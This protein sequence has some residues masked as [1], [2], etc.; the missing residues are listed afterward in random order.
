MEEE[1]STERPASKSQDLQDKYLFSNKIGFYTVKG[2]SMASPS[3]LQLPQANTLIWWLLSLK[4]L[5]SHFQGLYVFVCMSAHTWARVCEGEHVCGRRM[6]GVMFNDS[7]SLGQDPSI[8]LIVNSAKWLALLA[9][10]LLGTIFSFKGW[11]SMWLPQSPA[12][13]QPLR[14]W[15]LVL[16]FCGK[17]FSHWPIFPDPTFRFLGYIWWVSKHSSECR[18]RDCA[19]HSLEGSAPISNGA[20][21]S[22]NGLLENRAVRVLNCFLSRQSPH[23]QINGC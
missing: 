22:G 19:L 7:D 21:A 11:N 14:N 15:A 13:T 12:F 8:Q 17:Y 3:C 18:H 23:R 9:S 6:S 5:Q 4:G 1:C 20:F 10:F 16:N 2:N